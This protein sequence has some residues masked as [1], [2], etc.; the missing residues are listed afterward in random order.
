MNKE[1]NINDLIAGCLE[2]LKTACYSE[3]CIAEYRRLWRAG[4]LKYMEIRKTKIF[5]H[6]LGEDFLSNIWNG[7][8]PANN[9]NYRR[10]IH[11]LQEYLQTGIVRKRIKK[12]VEHPLSGEIGEA[13]LCFL[14]SLRE[15][16]Y[17]QL[18]I[19]EKRYILSQFVNGL[20]IKG[21][22]K[23]SDITIDNVIS[24]VDY[25]HTLKKNRFTAIRQFCDFLY[26]EG[27]M[28]QNL[29]YVLVRNNFPQREKLPSTYTLEEISMIEASIE[30]SSALGKRDYAI[31]LIASLLGL[32]ASDIR[33]LTWDNIDWDN[34]KITLYQYK[35]GRPLEL[36]LPK[37]V[38]EAIV[39]YALD[40]RPK[41]NYSE[42]FLSAKAPY[43][44]LGR[45][46][47]TSIIGKI[48][49]SSGVDIGNRNFG[50]HSLRNTLASSLLLKETS[51]STISAILGH[52]SIQSTMNYLRID[53]ESLKKCV[54]E[55]SLVDEAFYNQN[56]GAFYE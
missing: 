24:A 45:E 29:S 8:I 16:R 10:S 22:Y 7:K 38:G 49:R 37:E 6:D 53:L 28:S 17:S 15:L 26:K 13:A 46:A 55:A 12:L 3:K 14:E 52:E 21:I 36:P 41:S 5:T 31:F 39:T 1:M 9:R 48:I 54:L 23:I 35:T 34:G 40:A 47:I 56:G 18:T 2:Q 4:I 30:R 33:A 11:V 19:S 42:V 25:S 32:R 51:I 44:P 27:Y 50:P 43:I 20:S